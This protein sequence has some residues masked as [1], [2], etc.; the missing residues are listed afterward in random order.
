MKFKRPGITSFRKIREESGLTQKDI[1]DLTGVSQ[2]WVHHFENDSPSY[3][4]RTYLAVFYTLMA[5]EVHMEN[6]LF[7]EVQ[8]YA[9]EKDLNYPAT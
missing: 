5:K 9:K 6:E 4:A 1:S 8:N 3:L 2:T 7:L